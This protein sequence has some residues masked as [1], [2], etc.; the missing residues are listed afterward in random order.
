MSS[1]SLSS[2][3]VDIIGLM[4]ARGSR[5]N[6]TRFSP[7]CS[8]SLTND[9]LEIHRPPQG[10]STRKVGDAPR[11]R[12][13]WPKPTNWAESLP[14]DD[15]Q[16]RIWTRVRGRGGPASSLRLD[17]A[18]VDRAHDHG[19]ELLLGLAYLAALAPID[20][21]RRRAP[22]RCRSAGCCRRC[23]GFAGAGEDR[24]RATPSSA[25][26]PSGRIATGGA[27]THDGSGP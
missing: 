2:P 11:H 13:R 26:E 22:L 21:G 25:H 4:R 6:V 14:R 12:G 10:Q 15:P 8:P 23:T 24:A 9:G 20:A 5:R 18:V 19:H 17:G 3:L 27:W 16:D 1:F 7:R